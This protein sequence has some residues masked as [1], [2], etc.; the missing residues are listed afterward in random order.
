[1]RLIR[2]FLLSA[3]LLCPAVAAAQDTPS[4]VAAGFFNALWTRNWAGAAALVSNDGIARYRM[5][6]VPQAAQSKLYMAQMA[7]V[8]TY[9]DS[10]APDTAELLPQREPFDLATQDTVRL[11]VFGGS[12]SVRQLLDMPAAEFMTRTLGEAFP[13]LNNEGERP[14]PPAVVGE[15]VRGDSAYVILAVP[16]PEDPAGEPSFMVLPVQ[17]ENGRWRVTMSRQLA[18]PFAV[19]TLPEYSSDPDPDAGS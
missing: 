13:W 3:A 17:R 7:A 11:D 14:T 6:V 16:D 18:V 4:Q 10:V 1:M 15:V 2:T 8:V 5:Q 19:P 12:Y 9:T